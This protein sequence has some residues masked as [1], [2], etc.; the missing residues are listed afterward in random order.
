MYKCSNGLQQIAY[1]NLSE[2]LIKHGLNLL[3]ECQTHLSTTLDCYQ[4]TDI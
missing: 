4:F 3:A 2:Q 1:D